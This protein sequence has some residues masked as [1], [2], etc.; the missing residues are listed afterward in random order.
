MSKGDFRASNAARAGL[1]LED[2][3]LRVILLCPVEYA[4]AADDLAGI[5]LKLSL[6]EMRARFYTEPDFGRLLDLRADI[7]QTTHA[8]EQRSIGAYIDGR[9]VEGSAL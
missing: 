1:F 3:R 4:L 7:L 8:L 9:I 2:E 6:E 5:K